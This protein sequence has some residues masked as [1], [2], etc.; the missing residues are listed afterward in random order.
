MSQEVTIEKAFRA[1]DMTSNRNRAIASLVQ[2][3]KRNKRAG[4]TAKTRKVENTTRPTWIET[5]V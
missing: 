4:L 2:F 5:Y 3:K 1:E